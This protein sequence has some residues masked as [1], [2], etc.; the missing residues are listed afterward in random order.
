MQPLWFESWLYPFQI[1]DFGQISSMCASVSPVRS[2]DTKKKQLPHRTV[3]EFTACVLVMGLE[4]GVAIVT[5][6]M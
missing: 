5:V 1:H 2:G 3:G 6:S 4:V